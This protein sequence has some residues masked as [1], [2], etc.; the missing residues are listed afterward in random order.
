MVFDGLEIDMLSL[1]DADCILV[2]QWTTAYGPF[3][4]LIDGGSGTDFK[5]V[6]EFLRTRNVTVLYAVVCTHLHNDHASG[7]IKLVQ[8][9]S[10]GIATAWMHDVRKH[11]SGEAL[12]RASAGNSS[13][14][15]SVRQVVETTKELASAFAGRQLIPKEPFAGESISYAPNLSVLG[16]TQSFYKSALGEFTRVDVPTLP[17]LPSFSAARSILGGNPFG[18]PNLAPKA[19]ISLPPFPPSPRAMTLSDLVAGALSKSSVKENPNT[20]PFNNTSAIIGGLFAGNKL[21][22]TSDAG[23]DALE[24]IPPDWKDLLWMQMPH[25]GSDE[26]LSQKNIER[27]CP[28]IAYVSACGDTSHPD[29]AIVNGLIKVGA[30]VFSTHSLSPGHLWYWLG[31]VPSRAGY[32]PAIPLKGTAVPVMTLDWLSRMHNVR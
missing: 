30:Q 15:D 32:G 22:F 6:R 17:L 13:Q 25:H 26:N 7:L 10:I 9:K 11:V 20:Q 1:G 31:A 8:D 12:R 23:A 21:L 14:A 16:P 28:K 5:T 24:L 3:R 18:L 27:F 4:V 29:K 2:T 19:P